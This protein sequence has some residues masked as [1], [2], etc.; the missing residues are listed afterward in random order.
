VDPP[1]EG[2]PILRSQ[3]PQVRIL[4]RAHAEGVEVAGLTRQPLRPLRRLAATGCSWSLM[5]VQRYRR[6]ARATPLNSS[7][8][9]HGRAGLLLRDSDGTRCPSFNE[10]RPVQLGLAS[11]FCDAA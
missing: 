9:F 7:V 8:K 3:R 10:Q 11:L 1:G 5:V 4:Y 2:F 6:R